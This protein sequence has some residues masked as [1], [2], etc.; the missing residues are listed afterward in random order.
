MESD[1]SNKPLGEYDD[2]VDEIIDRFRMTEKTGMTR[3]EIKHGVKKAMVLLNLAHTLA[4]TIDYLVTDAEG[5]L[6][7]LGATFQREDKQRFKRMKEC[8]KAARR[9]AA[10]LCLP[11]YRST[12]G[13]EYASDVEWWYNF[14]RM[15]QD[16]IGEDV[17]KTRLLLEYIH[18][19]TSELQMFKI[20]MRDFKRPNL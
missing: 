12:D 19:M 4:D 1:K 2:G 7:P 10:E 5:I 14:V 6:Q 16:R 13:E 15:T 17:T 9:T 18:A 3:E 11:V 8:L 20:H